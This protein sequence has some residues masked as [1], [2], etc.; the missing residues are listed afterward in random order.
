MDVPKNVNPEVQDS[1]MNEAFP[2]VYQGTFN[3][4]SVWLV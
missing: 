2:D 1:T 3:V 4:K